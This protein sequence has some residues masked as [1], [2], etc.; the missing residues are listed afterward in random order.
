M[1]QGDPVWNSEKSKASPLKQKLTK[2]LLIIFD[3]NIIFYT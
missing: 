2:F 3:L 1:E